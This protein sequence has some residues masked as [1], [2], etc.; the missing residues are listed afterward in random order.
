M[1]LYEIEALSLKYAK[2]KIYIFLRAN[3]DATIIHKEIA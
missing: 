2:V 3:W 1:K